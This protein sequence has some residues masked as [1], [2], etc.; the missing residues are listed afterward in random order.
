MIAATVTDN[1]LLIGAILVALSGII[2][3]SHSAYTWARSIDQTMTYV[4]HE[5]E[6]NSGKTMRDAIQ[7]I[8]TRQIDIEAHLRQQ[9]ERFKDET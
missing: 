1:I 6:L 3:F 4:K 9:D 7:R 5:M 8:E 2:K